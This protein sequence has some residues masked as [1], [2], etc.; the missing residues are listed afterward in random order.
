MNVSTLIVDDE[1]LARAGLRD[2]LSAFDW[3]TCVGEAGSGPA[4]VEAINTLR[5]DLVFLDIQMPG[6][7][8]TDLV[9]RLQHEPFIVFTTA[10]A[11][12]AVTAFELGAVDYLLKPFGTARLRTALERARSAMGEASQATSI[13][14]IR[15]VL[16]TAPMTRLFVRSGRAIIPLAVADVSWLEAQGDYVAAH[17]GR[18]SYMLHL[19]LNRLEHRLDPTRFVR[20]HRAY[21][22]NLDH[23][24]AFRQ[25]GQGGLVAELGD[26]T[27][28]PVSRSRAH[29]LRTR[30]WGLGVSG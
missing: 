7:L 26:G 21:I 12:H 13:E 18:L 5:P 6:M 4:A 27:R 15:E 29:D 20:I 16:D 22:A 9:R 24:K 10:Y 30:G 1:P 23:V 28:L 14:R 8:G 19:A 2:M 11:Q 17:V 25:H 3:I